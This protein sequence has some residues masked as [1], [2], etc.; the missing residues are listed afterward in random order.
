MFLKAW[1]LH[2]QAQN[3]RLAEIK[4]PWRRPEL[5]RISV[6][7]VGATNHGVFILNFFQ[8]ISPLHVIKVFLFFIM[9]F[10]LERGRMRKREKNNIVRDKH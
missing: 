9:F 6:V 3:I 5:I 7:D 1:V 2:H 10:V 4:N 8:G